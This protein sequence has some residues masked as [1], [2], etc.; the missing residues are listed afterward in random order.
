[1]N[2][3]YFC[4]MDHAAS[5]EVRKATSKKGRITKA[6]ACRLAA[7]GISTPPKEKKPKKK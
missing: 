2:D 6:G 5:A 7:Q 1:M 4:G 3:S